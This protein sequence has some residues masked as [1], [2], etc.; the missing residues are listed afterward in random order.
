MV[1]VVAD[2]IAGYP[3]PPSTETPTLP[4]AVGVGCYPHSGLS[5]WVLTLVGGGG[6]SQGH[7]PPQGSLDPVAGPP[8]NSVAPCLN[9]GR[10]CRA[11]SVQTG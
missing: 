11:I 9:S 7:Y 10:L 4:P 1:I 8:R 6:L 5:P 2:A 3:G